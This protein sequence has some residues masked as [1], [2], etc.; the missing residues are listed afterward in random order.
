MKTIKPNPPPHTKKKKKGKL[1]VLQSVGW[2]DKYFKGYW[3]KGRKS[4]KGLITKVEVKI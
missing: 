1:S 3:K 2:F 4:S